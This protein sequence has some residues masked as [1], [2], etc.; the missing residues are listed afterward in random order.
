MRYWR[1]LLA[2][3]LREMADAGIRRAVGVILALQQCDSSWQQY[4]REVATA[5]QIVGPDAPEVEYLDGWHDHPLFIEA[6]VDHLREALDQLPPD[7]RD[8]ARIIFTAHSIPL[9]MDGADLYV[10]QVREC[11]E[12]SMQ[13]LGRS[14][15]SI[16]YQ[17]RT[18]NPRD[19]WLEPDICGVLTEFGKSGGKA[20]VLMP[21]GFVCDHVEVLFDLDLDASRVAEEA[22]VTVVRAKTVGTHPAYIRMFVE[23]ITKLCV[24]N[25][26]AIAR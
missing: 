21:I 9:A 18:G 19:P 24:G 23:L 8:V 7:R 15:W 12:R 5:R 17:S 3:T 25:T 6:A 14:D 4:Q 16:A 10:R 13:K 1:P 2:E 22:G 11:A 26:G 20:A